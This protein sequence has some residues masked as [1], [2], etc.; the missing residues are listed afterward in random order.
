MFD[1]WLI[2]VD[3]P[4]FDECFISQLSGSYWHHCFNALSAYN[5]IDGPTVFLQDF[6]FMANIALMT[7]LEDRGAITVSAFLVFATTVSVVNFSRVGFFGVTEGSVF[8][9]IA[10]ISILTAVY[11]PLYRH[12]LYYLTLLFLYWHIDGSLSALPKQEKHCFS[13]QGTSSSHPV[14]CHRP[15]RKWAT[16]PALAEYYC[17]W[18]LALVCRFVFLNRLGAKAF[19]EP[20]LHRLY[21]GRCGD[22]CCYG[23]LQISHAI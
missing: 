15:H 14:C 16:W 19:V 22:S 18:A 17:L 4:L 7:C 9:P 1:V 23:Y 13:R 11:Y 21:H 6:Y 20:F 12:G 5:L 10:W 3:V 8:W 2:R